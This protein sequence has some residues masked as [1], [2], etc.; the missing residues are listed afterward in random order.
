MAALLT[1][2]LLASSLMV[3]SI[4]ASAGDPLPFLP[5][6]DFENG[7]VAPWYDDSP[8]DVNWAIGPK[9]PPVDSLVPSPWRGSKYLRVIRR[10]SSASGLAV[11]RSPAF[12]ARPGD[13]VV[14]NFFIRSKHAEGSSLEVRKVHTFNLLFIY[15]F[16]FGCYAHQ[17][18]VNYGN[19][20]EEPLIAD[21]S[22][23]STVVQNEWRNTSVRIPINTPT[24]LTVIAISSIYSFNFNIINKCLLQI[25]YLLFF[26]YLV[27]FLWLLRGPFWGCH[28]SW[29]HLGRWIL[30]NPPN[31]NSQTYK[32]KL[33]MIRNNVLYW[34][35]Y[36]NYTQPAAALQRR[37]PAC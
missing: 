4:E 28:S 20:R 32:I 30:T 21:L 11:L 25:A 37:R 15:N 34:T 2:L 7:L 22:H 33:S 6:K 26:L 27:G 12:T 17:L 35:F 1:T 3:S 16:S 9:T 31:H 19:G 10:T 24:N 5:F 18:Y 8:V 14:F 23:Y 29:R 13:G 36:C